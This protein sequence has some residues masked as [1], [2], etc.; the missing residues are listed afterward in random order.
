MC[1]TVPSSGMQQNLHRINILDL[2]WKFHRRTLGPSILWSHDNP[3]RHAMSEYIHAL[4]GRLRI[5]VAEVKGAPS[6]ALEI[7]SQLRQVNGIDHVSANPMTG[8]I[9]ILYDPRR[10]VQ[11]EIIDALRALG[12]LQERSHAQMLTREAP[13]A[14]AKPGE[15]LAETLVRSTMELA[16]QGLFRALI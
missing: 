13:A 2:L 12:G 14:R 15:A 10:I 6:K 5:K 7:E 11:Q 1:L 8:N 4:D 3:M 16:L 9:L